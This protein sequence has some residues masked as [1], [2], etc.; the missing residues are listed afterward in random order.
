[1]IIVHLANNK[2]TR[3]YL[4]HNKIPKL[5]KYNV[6]IQTLM[7]LIYY[8]LYVWCRVMA[9]AASATFGRLGSLASN[10]IFGLLIDSHCILLIIIF[11]SFLISTYWFFFIIIY[12]FIYY[13]P[14]TI[15]KRKIYL[16]RIYKQRK[17]NFCFAIHFKQ[18]VKIKLN[19]IKL[20]YFFQV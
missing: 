18:S 5:S 6:I 2:I 8:I 10:I 11:S 17:F 12:S 19:F 4:Y 16:K 13:I 20:H 3:I 14:K 7:S 15:V 9:A 1:M